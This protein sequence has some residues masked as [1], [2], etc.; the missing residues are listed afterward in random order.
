M[1]KSHP[2][3]EIVEVA[4]VR[5]FRGLGGVKVGDKHFKFGLA[6]RCAHLS[7]IEEEGIKTLQ[8]L[9]IRYNF[10][11]RT[12]R[13]KAEKPDREIEGITRIDFDILG[14]P[15]AGLSHEKHTN[16]KEF[17][18]LAIPMTDLYVVMLN[19]CI[20]RYREAIAKSIEC[21]LNGEPFLFHCSEGKDRT[22]IFAMLLLGMLGA[23]KEDIL[24]DYMITN[25]IAL[26]RA[27]KVAWSSVP[28]GLLNANKAYSLYV[29][30]KSYMRSAFAY[31]DTFG[32]FVNFAKSQLG[33]TQ[34]QIDSLRAACLE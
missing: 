27:R 29:A 2:G 10:D 8:K 21:L 19:G 7:K 25:D 11:L 17:L 9:N 6:F 31:I 22:G 34:E 16:R 12:T 1:G 5:N 24:E 15:T 28:L 20:E 32:G 33:V 18:A 4:G 26:A 3:K 30:K 14:A 13:E 23:S